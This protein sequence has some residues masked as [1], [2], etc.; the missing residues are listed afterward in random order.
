[1]K[2]LTLLASVLGTVLSQ[3]M[4]L[5]GLAAKVNDSVITVGDV[6]GEIKRNRHEWR[7]GTD[8]KEL[9]A[10]TVDV[11]IDRRLILAEAARKKMDMQEWMVDNRIREIVKDGFDGDMNKLTAML[12]QAKVPLTDWRN[13]IRDDM[14]VQA[15][16]YQIIDKNIVA[17]PDALK[18]EYTNHPERYQ[19]K[20]ATTVSV[21]LLRPPADDKT[22]S[23][24]TRGEELLGRLGKG[25]DFADLARQYSADSHAKD[26]GVWKDVQPADAFR[27]EI[28]EAIA[29]LKIGEVSPLINLDGWGF[30]VRKDAENAEQKLSFAEAY[31]QIERNVK[32]ELGKAEHAAWIKRLRAEAFIKTYPAPDDVK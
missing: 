31:E 14:I 11:L 32:K 21:I 20:A 29:K 18:R 4:V 16:R 17:T 27:A 1:M 10:R 12:D 19:Q 5:D 7:S 23:V 25:A 2:T 9:Y 13:E 15:M 6:M 22:P 3:A 8:L 28:A 24:S 30:I 26:G